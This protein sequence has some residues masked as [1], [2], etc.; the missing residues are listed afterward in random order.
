MNSEQETDHAFVLIEESKA[1]GKLQH[2]GP[3]ATVDEAMGAAQ[4]RM[5]FVADTA[6][7]RPVHNVVRVEF[8]NYEYAIY[9]LHQ[10]DEAKHT[11]MS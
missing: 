1:N 6:W 7:Q 5:R 9:P 10:F 8:A 11:T 2:Y 3:F 4:K